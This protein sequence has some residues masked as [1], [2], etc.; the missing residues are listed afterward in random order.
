MWCWQGNS[1]E[2]GG[3][4]IVCRDP[5]EAGLVA[6]LES[7]GLVGWDKQRFGVLEG[8]KT[9]KIRGRCTGTFSLMRI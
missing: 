9:D 2:I 6:L 5:K 7:G 4:V 8:S 1:P 3:C